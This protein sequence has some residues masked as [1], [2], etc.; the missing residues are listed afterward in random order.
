M[1]SFMTQEAAGYSV[2]T[3]KE[4]IAVYEDIKYI[5]ETRILKAAKLAVADDFITSLSNKYETR[6]SKIF[7]DGTDL[8]GGQW[9]RIAV[10]RQFYA[11][12]PLVILDE[13]TSAIDPLAEAKIFENLYEH[14][15]NKTVIV[16]SHRY[17]TVR[18]AQHIIVFKDGEIIEEGNHKSLLALDGYYAKS[19]NAQNE[20]KKL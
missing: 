19:F 6:L 7:T 11:N 10:A 9:Q 14:V 2:F 18:A 4:N 1:M 17:N 5:D 16:V 13:P 8:S 15:K 12:R 20:E 3:A